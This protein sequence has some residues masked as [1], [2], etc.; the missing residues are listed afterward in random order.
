M[1]VTAVVLDY[2]ESSGSQSNMEWSTTESFGSMGD[3]KSWALE[4]AWDC[5]LRVP[6]REGR[7]PRSVAELAPLLLN[8][9]G[10][11]CA[12]IN[13]VHRVYGGLPATLIPG[14]MISKH[15]SVADIVITVHESDE[16]FELS[17][18]EM[19]DKGEDVRI[20][21]MPIVEP[22]LEIVHATAAE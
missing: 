7:H 16:F 15:D 4:T 5:L 1:A 20:L 13:D 21:C 18:R 3:A 2:F 11:T 6:D 14:V 9:E 17:V 19:G 8:R 12:I 22:T 10:E